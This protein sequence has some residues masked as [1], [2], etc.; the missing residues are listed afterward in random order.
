MITR[1]RDGDLA[2]LDLQILRILSEGTCS[3]TAAADLGM[4][5][6]TLER[7]ISAIKTR[8][9][10]PSTIAAVVIAIRRGLI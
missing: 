1:L 8:L 2:D 5:V 6:R 7:R 10:A 4:S 3:E 9:G